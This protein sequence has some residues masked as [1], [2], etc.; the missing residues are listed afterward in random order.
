[1]IAPA[2]LGPLG[3]FTHKVAVVNKYTWYEGALRAV[4]TNTKVHCV[5]DQVRNTNRLVAADFQPPFLNS[6]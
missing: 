1:M 5:W 4:I 6:P 2:L 3:G